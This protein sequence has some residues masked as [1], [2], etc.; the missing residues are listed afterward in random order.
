ML[1]DFYKLILV[2]HRQN[3]SLDEYLDFIKK[4][5][6]SGVTCVQL[7]E[8]NAEPAFKLHFAQ[9]LKKL[10]TPY[11]IPL[12]INDDIDL[13]LH[14]DADG[15]HLG[16]SDNSPQ[17][18][19]EKLGNNKYIGL[20]IESVNE[21]EQ[22]NNFVLN[23]VAASAVF[24]SQHKNNLKMIWGLEGVN[25]LCQQTKHPVVGIGG[26]TQHNLP[27]LMQ[28]GAQGAAVIG[29]LHQAENPA[30]MASTLRQI[31][32]DNEPSCTIKDSMR[33]D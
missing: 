29:I 8:K 22:A 27:Q 15:V 32:L 18:A 30:E 33:K 1:N 4:C 3:S 9:S 2:T 13:A 10:L 31:I 14:I 5:I 12:M 21:L 19:R 17:I 6:S 11:N 23:Y 28:A 7:R 25:Q 20:S 16:Q 24:P 26:I